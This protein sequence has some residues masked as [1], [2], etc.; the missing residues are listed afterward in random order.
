MVDVLKFR[1]GEVVADIGCGS[2]FIS[3]KIAGKIGKTGTVYG[4]EI[5]QEMLDL[6]M[7]NMKRLEITTVKPVLGA[8]FGV[9][10]L[11]KG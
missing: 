2:G 11:W 6:L 10:M 9:R 3:R 4:V 5:Q 7:K 1:D 8:L